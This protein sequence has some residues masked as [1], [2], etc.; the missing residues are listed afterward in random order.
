MTLA[1]NEIFS[2]S[3]ALP[4]IDGYTVLCELGSGTYGVVYAAVDSLSDAPVA[5]KRIDTGL[6]CEVEDAHRVLTELRLLRLIDHEDVLRLRR[7]CV[8]LERGTIDIVT[9]RFDSDLHQIICANDNLTDDHHR[10]L[11]FQLLRGL[12]FLAGCGVVHRDLKPHNILVNRNCKLVIADLG[13]ACPI[14]SLCRQAERGCNMHYVTTRWYRAP[15]LCGAFARASPQSDVWAAGCVIAE[16]LSRRP[17]FEGRNDREQLALIVRFLGTPPP[18][19][20]REVANARTRSFITA[21]GTIEAPSAT[22]WREAFPSASDDAIDLVKRMLAFLPGD[23]I[24]A[25]EALSHPYFASLAAWAH[26]LSEHEEAK[27]AQMIA[28]KCNTEGDAK[29]TLESVMS[30]IHAEDFFALQYKRGH[31]FGDTLMAS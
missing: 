5:I 20:L 25:T 13:L 8:S 21:L 23:R 14:A 27:L 7:V 15:E 22:R 9:D 29:M 2:R 28:T 16:L 1:A 26:R 4:D 17:M 18:E 19:K 6:L 31:F 3:K 12:A 24:T 11:A 10:I 30:E